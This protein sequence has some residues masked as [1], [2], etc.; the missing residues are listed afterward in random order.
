MLRTAIVGVGW[1]GQ[2]LVDSIHGKGEVQFVVGQTRTKSRAEEF[3][4]KRDI[5][6]VDDYA[7]V[8]ADPSVDAVVLATPHSQHGEQVRQAAAAGKHVFCE[9]PFTLSVA[10]AESAIAAAK[11]AGIVL[12]VG[13]NRRFHPSMRELAKR[14]H[15]G[16]LGAIGTV[17]GHHTSFSSPAL[18]ADGWRA[19]P[20]EAPAGAMTAIGV[21]TLDCMIGLFG[22]VAEVFCVATRRATP[23]ADDTTN[24]V[25]KFANGVTGHI[26][27]SISSAAH[28][29]FKVFGLKGIAE[30][31][32]P[33]LDQFTFTPSPPRPREPNGAP[34][35]LETAKFDTLNAELAAFAEAVAGK[36]PFPVPL[37]EVMMGVK[38]FEAIVRSAQEGRPV[39]VD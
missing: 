8:L 2:T 25:V 16:G 34:E 24:V 39:R 5:R 21:H 23:Q 28:Y 10:D 37:D 14:V 32:K 33:N 6:L 27:C 30:I 20:D 4:R 31:S 17:T 9:K 7:A 19:S 11:R 38:A 12:A 26:F 18:T 1:W 15:A 3:C 13:F 36:A 35:I 22:P 29:S